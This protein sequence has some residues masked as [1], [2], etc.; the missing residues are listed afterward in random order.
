MTETLHVAVA[1]ITDSKQRVLIT[2]RALHSPQGGLWEFPG[3]KLESGETASAALI[4]E[5]QE[6]LGLTITQHTFIE[7]ITHKYPTRTVSLWVYHVSNY[8]GEARCCE[9]QQDLRWVS[10]CDLENHHLLEASQPLISL[11]HQ[12]RLCE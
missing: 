11:I 4:R 3:G 8:T 7:V 2:K 1:V 12:H 9:A 5:I 10:V 6:E